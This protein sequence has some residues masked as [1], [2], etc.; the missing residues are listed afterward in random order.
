VYPPGPRTCPPSASDVVLFVGRLSQEKGVELLLDAWEAADLVGLRLALVGDGPLRARVV[1]HRSPDVEWRGWLPR[2]KVNAVMQAG[3]A[4]V[5]PSQS[6]EMFA[7]A[8]V[9]AMA[10]GLPVLASDIGAMGDLVGEAGSLVPPHNPQA[11]ADQLARLHNDGMVDHLGRRAQDRYRSN[12][13]PDVG[14]ELLED[15]YERA[16]VTHASRRAP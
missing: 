1:H 9:E 4:L 3:R 13:T 5:L 7:L 8:G 12:F 14:L 2:T 11:W 15:A 16:H 10:A 6:Y